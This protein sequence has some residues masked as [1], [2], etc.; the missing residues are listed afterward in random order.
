MRE[1]HLSSHE[2]VEKELKYWNPDLVKELWTFL[3]EIHTLYRQGVSMNQLVAIDV[4]YWTNS[5]HV[6]RSYGPQGKCVFYFF[7]VLETRP[8]GFCSQAL[9]LIYSLIPRF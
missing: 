5:G 9:I 4:C 3:K 7:V 1:L 8:F 2:V 6:V